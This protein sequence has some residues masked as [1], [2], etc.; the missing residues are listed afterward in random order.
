MSFIPI[1]I[2]LALNCTN[3]FMIKASMHVGQSE[4]IGDTFHKNLC[5]NESNMNVASLII[6]LMAPYLQWYGWIGDT[7]ILS[8]LCTVLRQRI[9]PLSKD[10]R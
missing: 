10:V 5:I 3:P 6:D 7:Y 1:I 2:I 4:P 9:L 8:Q